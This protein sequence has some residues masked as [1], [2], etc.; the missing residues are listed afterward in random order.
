[1]HRARVHG[2][3]RLVRCRPHAAAHADAYSYAAVADAHSFAFADAE[4]DGRSACGAHAECAHADADAYGFA[5]S[6]SHR[7][8][9]GDVSRCVLFFSPRS[10]SHSSWFRFSQ[11]PLRSCRPTATPVPTPVSPTPTVTGVFRLQEECALLCSLRTRAICSCIARRSFPR[12][13]PAPVSSQPASCVVDVPFCPAG[14]LPVDEYDTMAC[15]EPNGV[16]VF[17]ECCRGERDCAW[18]Y[19][20]S[21]PNPLACPAGQSP[22]SLISAW[23]TSC[24]DPAV[25]DVLTPLPTCSPELCCVL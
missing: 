16:C 6:E 5:Y 8:A 9:D 17:Q 2:D 7:F 13:T 11:H 3:G 24:V 15:A 1:M 22:M 4:P 12:P 10:A 20:A 23:L 25:L 21:N 19:S 18:Y 14:T